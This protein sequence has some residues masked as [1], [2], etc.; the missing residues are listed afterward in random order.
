MSVFMKERIL[1]IVLIVLVIIVV[2]LVY[3]RLRNI[4]DPDRSGWGPVINRQVS[5]EMIE[6]DET[7]DVDEMEE[8]DEG[9]W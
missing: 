2:L 9:T 1:T 8:V 7:E 5:E 6:A 3:S 4:L